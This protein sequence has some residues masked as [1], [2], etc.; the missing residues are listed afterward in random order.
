MSR[1]IEVNITDQTKPVSQAGFGTAFLLDPVTDVTN[2][3]SYTEVRNI[4]EIPTEASQLAQ[5]M[6]N[7]YL[8]QSPTAGVINMQGIYVDS[9]EGTAEN[10]VEALNTIY[11]EN[12]DWYGLLIASRTQADIEDAAGW[13]PANKL[14]ITQPVEVDFTALSAYGLAEFNNTGIFPSV[15]EQAIDAAIM[16]RMFATDPGSATWKW[17]TL[18]G[19]TSSGYSN[20]DVSSMLS[21]GEGEPFMNPVIYEKGIYYTAEG[22]TGDGSFLDI[23]RAIDWMEAR[24]T[25]NIFNLMINSNKIPYTDD[26]IAMVAA[27]LEEI[28]RL[29]VDRDVI[30][31]DTEG[32]PLYEMDIPSRTDIPTNTRANRILPDMDFEATVAGAV[33]S[34]DVAGVLKV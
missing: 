5:D 34:V 18:N 15:T 31:V 26:G 8:S 25:E 4:D 20:A 7:A 1:F 11:E 13:I 9:V 28:L 19:V 14:F 3:Y 30:A 22:K 17:K 10:V 2:E 29:A 23:T 33:H 6:A 32:V 24:M 12:D 21:P 27:K 16:A